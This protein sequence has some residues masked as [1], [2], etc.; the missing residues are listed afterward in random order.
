[1][2]MNE[3]RE[4][5]TEAYGQIL[6]KQGYEWVDLD[7]VATSGALELKEIQHA[8]PNK[9]LLCASWMEQTDI[10]A[11]KHHAE[12]LSSG[13]SERAVLDQYFE[14]LESFMVKYGFKGCPFTNTA[15]AIRDKS[16]PEIEQR[17]MEHK[18]EVRHF[19][20]RLS[21]RASSRS[22]HLGEALFLIYSGATTESANMQ[23]IKPIQSGREA[24]LA[25]LNL[26]SQR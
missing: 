7:D 23:N 1:M 5:A 26:Y 15:R 20:L 3:I 6:I 18:R 8:F 25:L 21:E 10:R 19:F 2:Q 13:K 16:E 14:E 24:S 22:A 17:I 9:A 11:R 12:L 4:K